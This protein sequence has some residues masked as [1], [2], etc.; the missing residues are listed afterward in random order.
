MAIPDPIATRE[1]TDVP[2]APTSAVEHSFSEPL[3]ATAVDCE[4]AQSQITPQITCDG[5]S[6][7]NSAVN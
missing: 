6:Q 7:D 1:L 3:E 5:Q 4:H 2:A